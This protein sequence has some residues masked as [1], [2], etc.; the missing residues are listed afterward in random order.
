MAI[1]CADCFAFVMSTHIEVDAVP[2]SD[3]ISKVEDGSGHDEVRNVH[4]GFRMHGGVPT[5]EDMREKEDVSNATAKNVLLGLNWL[6][7][8]LSLLI[9]IA[10]ILGVVIGEFAP[11]VKANLNKGNL[12]GVSAPLVIG[13]IVMMWP[14]LTKVRCCR[15]QSVVNVLETENFC[16]LQSRFR[17][18]RYHRRSKAQGSGCRSAYRSLSTGLWD[19]S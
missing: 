15:S 14:I 8:F 1:I 12:K 4:T 7:R 17:T 13:L 18:R 6:D 3:V 16:I 2:A 19:R 9:V 10:M 11:N 5:Y